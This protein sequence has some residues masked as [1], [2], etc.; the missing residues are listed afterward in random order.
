MQVFVY[1]LPEVHTAHTVMGIPSVNARF[2]TSPGVFNGLMSF[3]ADKLPA[4]V[5]SD[6]NAVKPL[7]CAGRQPSLPPYTYTYTYTP[8]LYKPDQGVGDV[9][10][11][12]PN[13]IPSLSPKPNPNP[14]AF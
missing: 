12:T 9:D 10:M 13:P 14:D 3:I 4:S 6:E 8:A 7:V 1:N 11:I 2:G 5:L